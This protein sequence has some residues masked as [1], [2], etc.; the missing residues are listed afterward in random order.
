MAVMALQNGQVP[1]RVSG[2]DQD[3]P[4]RTALVAGSSRHG[5]N[6]AVLLRQPE[7]VAA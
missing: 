3:G 6:A 2:V 7:P 5:S 4:L 1:G